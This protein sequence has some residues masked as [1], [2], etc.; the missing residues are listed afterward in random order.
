MPTFPE[1]RAAK[2]ER[3]RREA[4]YYT[5][6]LLGRPCPI[7]GGRVPTVIGVDFHPCCGPDV[8]ALVARDHRLQ[9]GT[10]A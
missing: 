1:A 4:R 7:C 8:A 2:A 9:K 3:S 5:R 10:K 6:D